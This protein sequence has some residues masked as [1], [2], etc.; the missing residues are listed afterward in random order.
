MERKDYLQTGILRKIKRAAAALLK[1]VTYKWALP[2]VYYW[3]ARKPVDEKLV[4]F[5]EQKHEKMPS[6]FVGLYEMCVKA[7]YRCEYVSEGRF[8]HPIPGQ[9]QLIML[10][11]SRF[12]FMRLFARCK[13]LFLADYFDLADVVKKRPETQVIQLWHACGLLKKWGYAAADS[14]GWGP[15]EKG[16]KR[17]PI[18]V[19][20]TLC[21]VSSHSPIVK[22]GYQAAFRCGADIVLPLGCPRTDRFFD[23]GYVRAARKRLLDRFPQIGDRK[24]LL[25][26]PT[27]RGATLLDS[28]IEHTLDIRRLKESL[29]EK[30]VLIT[31]FHPL[32]AGEGLRESERLAGS[33]FVFDVTKQM[34]AEEILPTADV[35]ITDYSSILFEFLLFERPVISYVFDIDEYV[36][37]RGFFHPYDELAPGPYVFNQDELIAALTTVDQWFD[38]ERVRQYKEK[39]MSACDGHSTERIFE[40]VFG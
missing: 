37:D 36:K 17:Y 34:T 24:I 10:M 13:V 2:F 30:Y 25:Y 12:R 27:Y 20:Q 14:P 15:T 33:D 26:A 31:K 22:A 6:N 38:V 39:F 7:G 21:A 4:V 28:Y 8:R 35:L 1:Y 3:N 23:D 29:S 32:M 18:Y 11:K 16:L 5:A 19:N 9:H 40:A